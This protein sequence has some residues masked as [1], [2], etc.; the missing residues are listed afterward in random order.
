M[1]SDCQLP[2]V[3]TRTR[4]EALQQVKQ[5]SLTWLR[6]LHSMQVFCHMIDILWQNTS[7]A[8]ATIHREDVDIDVGLRYF[9]VPQAV[10][11]S[12]MR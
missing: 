9:D 7:V 8:L 5:T 6:G 11:D 1:R 4:V 12:T 2:K 3:G 10:Q